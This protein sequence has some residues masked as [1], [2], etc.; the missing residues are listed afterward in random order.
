MAF[1]SEK[2]F[3]P[4]F[5]FAWSVSEANSDNAHGFESEMG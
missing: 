1:G 2:F 4:L 3:L 5:L